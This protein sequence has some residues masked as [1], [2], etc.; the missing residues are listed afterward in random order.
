MIEIEIRAT[1]NAKYDKIFFHRQQSR[2]EAVEK[3]H[4]Y[5]TTCI[6]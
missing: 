4:E 2:E 1:V 6:S 3:L 5:K